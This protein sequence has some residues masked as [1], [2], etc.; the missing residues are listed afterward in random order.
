MLRRRQLL[1]LLA[2]TPL[3]GC[4]Q[5]AAPAARRIDVEWHRKTVVDGL[6]ARWLA[7]SPTPSGMFLTRFDRQWQPLDRASVTLTGQCRLIYAMAVGHE[8]TQ[9]ARYLDAARRGANFLLERFHDPLHGGFF[10]AVTADGKPHAVHKQAYGQAFAVLALATLARVDTAHAQR[11]Q[12]EGLRAWDE[13]RLGLRDPSG[14]L[15]VETARNFPPQAGGPRTQNPVMHM[16]EALLALLEALSGDAAIRLRADARQLGDFVVYKLLEGLPDGSARIPEWYDASGGSWKP[17]PTRDKGGYI[18]L[19][20]QF[21]WTHLLLKAGALGVSPVYA[22]VAE[23]LLQYALKL[24]YDDLVGG[25]FDRCSPDQAAVERGKGDWQ[26]YEAL[27]GLI[28]AA[29]ATG[30]PDLWRRYEQTLDLVRAELIEQG[31]AC[32]LVRCG[33]ELSEP[34]HATSMHLAAIRAAAGG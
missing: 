33:K 26:Q 12:T 11:W 17:Q 13:A 14:G 32:R 15:Y 8:L 23:R 5:R 3:A 30:K 10:Y 24:G 22:S 21:E 34:Y 28:A 16:F 19:G 7:A 9:D 2:A 20:H 18:D 27:H 6:L 31:G 1:A 29:A 4:E 25:A